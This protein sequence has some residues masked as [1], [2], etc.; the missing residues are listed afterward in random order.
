MRRP[1]SRRDAQ[2]VAWGQGSSP[3]LNGA[4]GTRTLPAGSPLVIALPSRV[5]GRQP[6][7]DLMPED[8]D[9][10]GL[11]PP[12]V[13]EVDLLEAQVQEALDLLPMGLR[14]GRDKH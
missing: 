6:R 8:P 2:S 14:V 3:I 7:Q 13:V 11:V 5:S 1:T 12:D 4:R 10:L 9:P